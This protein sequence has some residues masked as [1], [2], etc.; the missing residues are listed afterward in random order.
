MLRAAP[1][2]SLRFLIRKNQHSVL[3]LL[4]LALC[5]K[6]LIPNGFM[7]SASEDTF[8]TV[9]ICSESSGDLKQI[10]MV[11]P[12]KEQGSKHSDGAQKGEHCVFAGLSHFA[13]GGANMFLL[14]LAWA[15][16]VVL[17]L[18]PMQRQPHQLISNLRP[19]LRGP[20]AA[21]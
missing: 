9:T 11:I 3:A 20:P 21:A 14:A 8:L 19:P 6:A 15:F 18:A 13:L 2:Y 17:G 16:L 5:I 7:V 4:M 1:M 12:G 10:Q